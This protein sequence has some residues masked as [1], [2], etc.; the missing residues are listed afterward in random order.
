MLPVVSPARGLGLSWG[1]A[2]VGGCFL[3]SWEGGRQQGAVKHLLPPRK[4]AGRWLLR[5]GMV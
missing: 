4:G 1:N 2:R 3:G 5:Y